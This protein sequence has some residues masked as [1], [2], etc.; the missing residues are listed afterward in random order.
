MAAA[1][2][3]AATTAAAVAEQ[4]IQSSFSA[5]STVEHDE[6][7]HVRKEANITIVNYAIFK[8]SSFMHIYPV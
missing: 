1:A 8:P 2:A 4:P 5:S 6:P 7:G 3:S